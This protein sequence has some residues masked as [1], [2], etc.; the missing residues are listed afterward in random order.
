MLTAKQRELLL[1]IDDRLKEG[2]IS[3]RAS[4]RCAKRST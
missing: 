4:T 3:A 1:F 2:G